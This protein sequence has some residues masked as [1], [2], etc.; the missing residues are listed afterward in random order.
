MTLSLCHFFWRLIMEIQ[1]TQGE[2]SALNRQ[3]SKKYFEYKIYI[4]TITLILICIVLKINITITILY[5][6]KYLLSLHNRIRNEARENFLSSD[7]S[8]INNNP[9]LEN[10][11]IWGINCDSM[12]GEEKNTLNAFMDI[13]KNMESF[14]L[15]PDSVYSRHNYENKIDYRPITFNES[16]EIIDGT[17]HDK[18]D[19]PKNIKTKF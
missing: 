1:S 5:F 4:Y 17:Y 8:L 9:L 3:R 18:F 2:D 16:P 15:R 11:S 13:N 14:L 12:Y 19:T 7:S 6:R 10:S